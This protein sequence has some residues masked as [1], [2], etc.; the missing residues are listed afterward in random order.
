M[1]VKYNAVLRGL[2]KQVKYLFNKLEELCLDNLC[3]P[4]LQPAFAPLYP[5]S[6]RPAG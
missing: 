6:T 3:A 5:P 1:F 4:A 2:P